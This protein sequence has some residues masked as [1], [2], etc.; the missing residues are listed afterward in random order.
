M[1]YIYDTNKYI[2]IKLYE[3]ELNRI[4]L[5]IEEKCHFPALW[6]HKLL[7]VGQYLRSNH[8]IGPGSSTI[9]NFLER[10][11]YSALFS[12]HFDLKKEIVSKHV[13]SRRF[14]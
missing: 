13:F 12:T 8:D 7:R 9:F 3:C 1:F 10:N 6:S 4:Q 5:S 11:P 14:S 2:S